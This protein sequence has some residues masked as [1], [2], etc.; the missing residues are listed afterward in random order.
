MENS[1]NFNLISKT[2]QNSMKRRIKAGEYGFPETEWSRVS[3]DAKNLIRGMLETVPEKRLTID[4]I[5]K[6][7]WI[8]VKL[9]QEKV[10]TVLKC[11]NLLLLLLLF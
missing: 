11:V 1:F 2:K 7:A 9:G 3:E 8:S 4:H 6:S 5:M 10:K